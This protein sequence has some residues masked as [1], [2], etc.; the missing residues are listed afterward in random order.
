MSYVLPPH[1][2]HLI[3][4]KWLAVSVKPTAPNLTNPL[5]YF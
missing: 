4:Y 1:E 5:E 2:Q 3:C